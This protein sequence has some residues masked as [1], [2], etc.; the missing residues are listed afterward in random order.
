[1]KTCNLD[2]ENGQPF[3]NHQTGV[4]LNE[5]L[6]GPENSSSVET[7]RPVSSGEQLG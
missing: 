4:T 6:G 1:M 5:I 2:N 7:H 3:L